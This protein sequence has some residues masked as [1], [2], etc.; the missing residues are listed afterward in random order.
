MNREP[1]VYIITNSYP[2]EKTMFSTYEFESVL[3][4]YKNFRILSFSGY[5]SKNNKNKN[6]IIYLELMDGIKELFFP[7]KIKSIAAHL[8]LFKHIKSIRL[9]DFIKNIY[10]YLMA[11][12]ILRKVDIKT[13]DLLFSYWL[14]RSSLIAFYL[15]KLIEN[16]YICQGHGSDLYI[17]PPGKIKDILD[18]SKKI[19]TVADNNY[20]FICNKYSISKEKVKVF[21]LGVSQEFY[22]EILE[23]KKDLIVQE[24]NQKVK[25]LTV[26]RYE[27][28][29]G[30]D[31]LLDAINLLVKTKKI[32]HNI[33]FNIYG[34]GSKYNDYKDFIEKNNL[35]KYI[36]LNK[37]INRKTLAVEL[38]R[39]NCYILPSRSE[40]LPVALMEAC[41][42]SL[43]IIATNVGSVREIAINNY[44]A[45]MC[46]EVNAVSLCESINVFLNLDRQKVENLSFSSSKVF[47][48]NYILE[49][50]L[51]EKY[52]YIQNVVN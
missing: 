15:N 39:S 28:V 51:K 1:L 43:P 44:N 19:F 45:I 16:D 14:T 6:N 30:I 12:S 9:M 13:D 32:T 22:N 10:S 18:S 36:N 35:Q 27:S 3:D 20:N 8:R 49:K 11:L 40:G 50:N 33:E 34:D 29:K 5:K 48:K 21:R 47:Q 24:D 23:H 41:A 46:N 37:W 2:E 7:T 4:N 26:A 25:F 17:Y 42:A 38:S 52:E 31:I